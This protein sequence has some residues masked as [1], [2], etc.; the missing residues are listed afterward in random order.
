MN[1]RIL[2]NLTSREAV[3][4]VVREIIADHE[5]TDAMEVVAALADYFGLALC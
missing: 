1:S 5:P 3:A 4:E 2:A